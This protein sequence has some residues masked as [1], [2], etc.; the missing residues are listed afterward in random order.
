[1][2][3]A[4]L[5]KKSR[6]I[7]AQKHLINTQ[8]RIW[9]PKTSHIS[10]TGSL[11]PIIQRKAT[12]ACDGYCPK[13]KISVLQT[14]LK[15]NKA[16]DQYEQ[17]ADLVANKVTT[18]LSL[19]TKEQSREDYEE[20]LIQLNSSIP[21]KFILRKKENK[22]IL[23]KNRE[24]ANTKDLLN[25]IKSRGN[26]LPSSLR[27][28][29][30]PILDYDFDQT[31]VFTDSTAAATAKA[32]NARAYTVGHNIVFGEGEYN[33]HT[34][35]G[36]HLLIHELIHEI[37]QNPQKKLRRELKKSN[38]TP[39]NSAKLIQ[40]QRRNYRDIKV[41]NYQSDN[42]QIRRKEKI[43]TKKKL[44]TED[45]IKGYE[46]FFGYYDEDLERMGR[47]LKAYALN[48]DYN[49]ILG[50]MN[51]FESDDRTFISFGLIDGL[52]ITQLNQFIETKLGQKLLILLGR[53][54]V[55]MEEKRYAL[56]INEIIKKRKEKKEKIDLEAEIEEKEE[57]KFARKYAKFAGFCEPYKSELDIL[58][59]KM[60][61]ELLLLP[62]IRAAYGTEVHQLWREYLSRKKGDSLKPK[63][64][65]APSHPIVKGFINDPETKKHKNYLVKRIILELKLMCQKLQLPPNESVVLSLK[66]LLP[67]SVLEFPIDFGRSGN[68]TI[69][70]L[71]A[72]GGGESDAG[73][74]LRKVA[75]KITLLR[76]T[77]KMGKTLNIQL[78]TDFIFYVKDAIDFCP[79]NPGGLLAQKFTIPLS[80]L[81]ASNEAYDVPFE[82]IYQTGPIRKNIK[83]PSCFK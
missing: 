29:L 67:S 62:F 14:K 46:S 72:G 19:K 20:G 68:P 73:K 69:P 74:D 78:E 80:R 13:C 40:P 49:F 38:I 66:D 64:F 9:N 15:L 10:S 59:A 52:S 6:Q 22:D 81:E 50:V 82:I 26:P 41:K 77:D 28:K 2:L 35:K 55:E 8:K 34:P 79:G 61:M 30:E 11:F 63:L 1:M 48:K 58:F 76:Q 32:I 4:N 36:Q 16:G 17:E 5:L 51:K 39:L 12:C 65:I 47:D 27:A 75:G 3:K 31:R 33:S 83:L 71:I 7:S 57:K 18:L 56:E 24:I 70:G 60:D 21:K 44:T 53:D 37:Q 23:V 43:N 45:F 54:M 42:Q 25:S